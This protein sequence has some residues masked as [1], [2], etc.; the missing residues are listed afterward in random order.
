MII[1]ITGIQKNENND[2]DYGDPYFGCIAMKQRVYQFKYGLQNTEKLCN[3]KVI[4]DDPLSV[5]DFHI[6]KTGL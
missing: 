5:V 1:M 3:S 2:D 6:C 4:D